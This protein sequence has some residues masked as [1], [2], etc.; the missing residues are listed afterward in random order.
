MK[1]SFAEISHCRE[2]HIHIEEIAFLEN[3]SGFIVA[4]VMLLAMTIE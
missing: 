2:P 3:I 1:N 4:E